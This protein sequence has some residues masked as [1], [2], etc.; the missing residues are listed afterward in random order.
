MFEPRQISP[1][2]RL[3]HRQRTVIVV[4]NL[5]LLAELTI[6]MYVGQQDPDNLTL[7]FLETFLP[8]AGLTLI[9]ARMLIRRLKTATSADERR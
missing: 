5:M 4:M 7:F 8:S 2:E 9:G 1:E 3:N 6:C